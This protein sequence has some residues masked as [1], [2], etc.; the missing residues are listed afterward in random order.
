M[1]PESV[2]NG[3]IRGHH[4]T[5][6]DSM[7]GELFNSIAWRTVK[8]GGPLTASS[9]RR[10]W[11][12]GSDKRIC[13]GT[14]GLAGFPSAFRDFSIGETDKKRLLIL[15]IRTCRKYDTM[16]NEAT[17]VEGHSLDQLISYHAYV[18]LAMKHS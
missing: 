8:R 6:K 10:S 14:D 15:Q 4:P 5:K 16:E 9:L 2:G 3:I 7:Q 17:S 18:G 1:A 13:T 12:S 11:I